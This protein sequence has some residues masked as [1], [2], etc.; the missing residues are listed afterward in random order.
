MR[1]LGEQVLA[2]WQALWQPIVQSKK[3]PSLVVLVS[4]GAGELPFVRYATQT[5]ICPAGG[6]GKCWDCVQ[7]AKGMHPD[8]LPIFPVPSGV[9]LEQLP[10]QAQEFVHEAPFALLSQWSSY[11]GSDKSLMVR[12]EQV[13]FLLQQLQL[14]SFRGGWRSVFFWHGEKLN[15]QSTNAL[16]KTLEEP[17]DQTIFWMSVPHVDTLPATLRSRAQ[18][19]R[20]PSLHDLIQ[21]ILPPLAPSEQ[22]GI[23][24]FVGNSVGRALQFAQAYEQGRWHALT[25]W[26][27]DKK[28][29]TKEFFDNLPSP[30]SQRFL[31][32]AISSV[33]SHDASRS[34]AQK[35]HAL[36]A[37]QDLLAALDSPLQ[38][39]NA[40]TVA[41]VALRQ[42]FSTSVQ[43][44]VEDIC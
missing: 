31:L 24:A 44:H 12:V 40:Y 16:L 6:C 27:Y 21:Q 38:L 3:V 29:L 33:I 20:A 7:V 22:K 32:S 11:L 5:L 1:D 42:A 17:P 30:E 28:P 43:G 37:L 14:R 19:W 25:R 41:H 34:P 10:R 18:L 36:T 26:I 35:L 23:A 4:D 13:R 2:A 15:L 39:P 8:F 9:E